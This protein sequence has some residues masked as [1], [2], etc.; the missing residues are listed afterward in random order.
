MLRFFRKPI[1][2][3]ATSALVAVGVVA[4]SQTGTTPQADAAPNFP[5]DFSDNLVASIASPTAIAFTPDGRML[6]TTQG[7]AL[8]VIAN[9]SLV[10]T[11]ALSIGASLC[12]N[13][14]RGMLGV[15]VD[16]NFAT[17]N[18]I[19]VYTTFN[20]AGQCVNRVMRYV[21]GSDNVA[22]GGTT[23]WDVNYQASAGNHNG[24]D[25]HFGADGYLYISIGDGG[26]DPSGASGCGG[27]NTATRRM[28]WLFG[29]IS[30]VDTNGV[31]PASN[32]F[33]GQPGSRRCGDPAG[34]P[35]GA[36]PCQ[37]TF[38]W[39]FRNPFRF[40]MQPGTSTFN[41]NDVG[42]GTWEEIDRGAAGA[43]F[44]WNTREGHCE[45]GSSTNC[46]APPAGMTNPLYDYNHSTGCSAIT[47]GAFVP[48]GNWPAP[49]AGSYL[50]AD[51]GCGKIMRLVDGGSGNYSSADFVTG[52]GGSSAT[53]MTFGPG[54]GGQ[55]MY[56]TSYAGG[57][58]VR[59]VDYIASSNHTPVAAFT[60]TPPYGALPLNSAFDGSA[61]S[62]ADPSDTLSYNWDFG[63]GTTVVTS[64]ATTSHTY[65]VFG[66]Y[67]ASLTVVDNHGATSA[68][69][70]QRMDPGNTPPSVNITSPSSSLQFV[71]GQTI[72]LSDTATDAEDGGA[73][74]ASRM[75][76]TITRRHDSHT[77]PFLGPL[78]GNDL[79]FTA[80]SP[81]DFAAAASSDLLISLT[82]SDSRGLSRT[83]TQTLTPHKVALNL[84]SS[85][86][87]LRLNVNGFTYVTPTGVVS[88]EGL[89]VTVIA[90]TQS[91]AQSRIATFMSWSDGGALKHSLTTPST[92]LNLTANFS[93]GAA[94]TGAGNWLAGSDGGIFSFGDAPYKGSHGAAPLNAPIV[95]M[96]ATP[97][98]NGYWMVATDGGIFSYG[99][100]GFYGS[101]GATRLNKPVVG[102]A[103]TPSGQ[104]YWMV[105]S[106]G[107]IF[108]F[109]DA[110]FYGSMGGSSINKPVVG[111]ARSATGLGYWL[112]ASDGGIFAFG[113]AVFYN[114]AG[115]LALQKPI[116]GMAA[117][118]SGNGYW[119]VASDGGVFTFGDAVFRGSAGAIALNQ[120]VLGMYATPNGAGYTLYASDGGLFTY[121][122]GRFFGSLGNLRLNGPIVAGALH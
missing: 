74:P 75:V 48:N 51:F 56:Y 103:S 3:A 29:K 31:P 36:G 6:V 114:S 63:D 108:A 81:E 27:G 67:T 34:T 119:L 7:G 95:G 70:T 66:T 13:S 14:E 38:S 120:P 69:V 121:G 5:S 111:I 25:V 18:Q 21:L 64:S 102:I 98:H 33:Y 39:G 49:Y 17:N 87:G 24:G 57:G 20:K 12:T 42:Q 83:I 88:W 9:N 41:V 43:D 53:S 116:V 44:G 46:G 77:H 79:T 96:A 94:P 8:R 90:P 30:R 89:P 122:N 86:G 106:D 62:D 104:G 16:P 97:T 80:P 99:D 61:S 2:I 32:P 118:R 85:P 82:V 59:R 100:A 54:F 19:Y 109:G 60:A 73:V 23:I 84:G 50:F 26:C 1:V 58:Q 91:D 71:V 72:T 101:M 78:T 45:T 47:G 113:D 28:D 112:V 52:L 40:A 37:E 117:T 107:G 115:G 11:A 76:W 105:A 92:P 68:P 10:P 65:T 55:S 22:T 35:A 15:A 4:L 93:L 110:G